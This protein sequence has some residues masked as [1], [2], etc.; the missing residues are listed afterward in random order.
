[1][2][3]SDVIQIEAR[4]EIKPPAELLMLQ[5]ADN[6]G[7]TTPIALAG[8]AERPESMTGMARDAT[9]E[10]HATIFK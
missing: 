2:I 9:I 10:K 1:M 8:R 4:P 7:A 5:C 6:I 3:V